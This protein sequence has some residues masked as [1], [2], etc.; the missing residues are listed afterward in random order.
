MIKIERIQYTI[1]RSMT[2]YKDTMERRYYTGLEMFIISHLN[3]ILNSPII[4][5]GTR[6][7]W[8]KFYDGNIPFIMYAV[9]GIESISDLIETVVVTLK[10]DPLIPTASVIVCSKDK[11]IVHHDYGLKA[12]HKNL[13]SREED[14][15]LKK[16]DKVIGATFS[17]I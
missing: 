8:T 15:L 6:V 14:K 7:E 16:G 3:R 2:K 4:S 12:D 17:I 10:F 13:F 1:D 5:N 9:S 11:K